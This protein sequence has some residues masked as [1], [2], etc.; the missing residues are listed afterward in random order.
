MKL[1]PTKKAIFPI[2]TILDP[3]FDQL[4]SDLEYYELDNGMRVLQMHD[5]RDRSFFVKAVVNAGAI[6]QSPDNRGLAHFVEHMVF[7][8]TKNLG[9]K[10]EIDDF[11]QDFDLSYNAFTSNTSQGF[12]ALSDADDESANA[13]C[14]F[15]SDVVFN[16]LFPEEEVVLEKQVILAERKMY[17]SDPHEYPFEVLDR[18]YFS[19]DDPLG[20]G[21]ILGLE[22]DIQRV[23]HKALVDFHHKYFHPENMLL[24]C[25]S[26]L[27][28]KQMRQ[29]LAKYFNKGGS[30]R[31]WLDNPIIDQPRHTA[32]QNYAEHK[33]YDNVRVF[34]SYYF[35]K[36][37]TFSF[38]D[39]ELFG[40]E[41]ISYVLSKRLFQDLRE[42]QGLAYSVWANLSN[43]FHGHLMLLSGEFPQEVYLT[44]R[45]QLENYMQKLV[46][47]PITTQEYKRAIRHLTSIRW[48]NSAKAVLNHV[49]NNLYKFGQ[50]TSPE[51]LIE[52]YNK[53]D[54]EYVQQLLETL[55]VEAKPEVIVVGPT[56]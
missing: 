12:H 24:I 14:K 43:I 10:K 33:D 9:D 20:G 17:N 7:K 8:G 26:G 34:V 55:F 47:E 45:E 39:K 46:D 21:G 27:E 38:P 28:S 53:L 50:F 18:H 35:P 30:R 23:D 11:A 51:F 48:A 5:D 1:K 6:H 54:L 16:P 15:V 44:A 41:V 32:S 52:Y 56:S 13:A 19:D 29:L 2:D 22:E 25:S 36:Q 37:S 4:V 42:N 31:G 49:A 3:K 40:L